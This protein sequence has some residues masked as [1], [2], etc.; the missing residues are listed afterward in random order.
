MAAMPWSAKNMEA[1]CQNTCGGRAPFVVVYLAVGE[2]GVGVDGGVH[3][4]HAPA[5]RLL[6]GPHGPPWTRQPPPSGIRTSFLTST[7][8]SWP[9]R[10]VTMPRM[11]RPV[12]RSNHRGWFSPARDSTRCTVDAGTPRRARCGPGRASAPVAA[13]RWPPRSPARSGADATRAGSAGPPARPPPRPANAPHLYAVARD[14]PSRR[15]HRPQG[16]PPRSAAPTSVDRSASAEHY[17]ASSAPGSCVAWQ[18]HTHP[19]AHSHA[20]PVNNVRGHY[21]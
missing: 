3:V 19:G 16:G 9:G 5:A 6:A 7:W 1:L 4:A 12:G 15:P 2:P 17:R 21:N 8:T 14:T 18:L 11:T 20:D 10:S 13:R